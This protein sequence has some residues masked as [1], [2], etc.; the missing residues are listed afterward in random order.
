MSGGAAR[1]LVVWLALMILLAIT[2]GGAF[3][4]LGPGN[5]VLA[6]GV[7]VAKAG[8]IVWFFMEMRQENGIA[9]L[10]AAAAFLWL[11]ILLTLSAADY[12]TR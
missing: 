12:L 11:A 5:V 1:T 6:Y 10:A 9:R 8:L 4:P 7:A 3:L 2:A